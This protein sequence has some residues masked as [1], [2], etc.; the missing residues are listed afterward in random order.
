MNMHVIMQREREREREKKERRERERGER[1]RKKERPGGLR[2][3]QTQG[4]GSLALQQFSNVSDIA[5]LLIQLV[6]RHLLRFV[7]QE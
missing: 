3:E 4:M 6:Y 7:P 2:A 5:Y 1:E